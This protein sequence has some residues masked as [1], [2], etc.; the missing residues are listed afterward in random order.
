MK[1]SEIIDRIWVW[2]VLGVF[3]LVSFAFGHHEFK[4]LFI[5]CLIFDLAW[6]EQRIFVLTKKSNVD[7]SDL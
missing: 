2:L 4:N 7:S 6:Y 1:P 3:W 5:S